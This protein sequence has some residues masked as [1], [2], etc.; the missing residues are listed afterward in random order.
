MPDST[1]SLPDFESLEIHPKTVAF[2]CLD[3]DVAELIGS[4]RW[5]AASILNWRMRSSAWIAHQVLMRMG[6]EFAPLEL[7]MGGLARALR[8]DVSYDA[9]ARWLARLVRALDED[10]KESGFYMVYINTQRKGFYK[11]GSAYNLPTLYTPAEFPSLFYAVQMAAIDCDLCAMNLKERRARQRSII[12]AWLFN[13]G[14][15]VIPKRERKPK[16]QKQI[17]ANGAEAESAR[18]IEALAKLPNEDFN[19]ELEAFAEKYKRH[20]MES[21][22]LGKE[23]GY[24]VKHVYNILEQAENEARAMVVSVKTNGG[25]KLVGGQPK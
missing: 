23:F 12:E 24:R 2:H 17:S 4:I 7:T 5:D 10:Q 25:I 3:A 6:G 22:T 13:R 15:Q 8:N 21:Y 9:G 14:C 19:V 20:L 1:P 16:Q 18:R 11:D